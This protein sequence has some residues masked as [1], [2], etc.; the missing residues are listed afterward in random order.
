MNKIAL[1]TLLSSL[2]QIGCAVSPITPSISASYKSEN[3]Y[4]AYP[5]VSRRTGEQGTVLLKVLVSEFGDVKELNVHISSGYPNLNI[6]ATDAV[7]N[8][9]FNPAKNAGNKAV[10]KWIFI[11]IVF[12]LDGDQFA[13][14][15]TPQELFSKAAGTWGRDRVGKY[16]CNDEPHSIRFEDNYS[17]AIFHYPHPRPTHDGTLKGE[18]IYKVLKVDG[19]TITMFLD[20]ETRKTVTGDPVVWSLIMFDDN[21]YRWHRTDD[22]SSTL[23]IPMFRCKP[24]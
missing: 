7:R 4:P 3:V 19:N 14:G 22:P 13:K 2:I 1:F 10:A 20:G 18:S 12:R 5:T 17:K 21:L 8:W 9:H 23:S 16:A 11:P 24:N 15:Y 6:A